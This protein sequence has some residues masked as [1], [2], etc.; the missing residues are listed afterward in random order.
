MPPHN[1]A[2]PLLGLEDG[3]KV[4]DACAAPGGK[5]GHMLEMAHIDLLALD[6]DRRRLRMIQ[7]N[8]ERLGLRADI[9]TGDATRSDWWTKACSIAFWPMFPVPLLV[10]LDDTRISAG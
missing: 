2:A 3:M 9:K 5:A 6:R 8:L 4:L 7:E 1:W 10:S